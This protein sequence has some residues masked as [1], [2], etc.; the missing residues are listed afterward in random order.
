ME[1][2]PAGSAPGSPAGRTAPRGV[3]AAAAATCHARRLAEWSLWLGERLLAP[4]ANRQVVLTVPKRLRPYFAHGC[5]RLGLLSRLATRTLR[6]Y[7]QASLG[8][9]AAVPGL[10]GGRAG[11]CPAAA[12]SRTEVD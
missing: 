12:E 4:V 10:I 2:V 7:V 11:G 6:A 3:P 5:R 1:R 8:E 9:G